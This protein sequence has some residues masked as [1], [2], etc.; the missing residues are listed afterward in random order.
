MKY[1]II[2][3]VIF[4]SGCQTNGHKEFYKGYD[5]AKNFP[6]MKQNI[7]FLIPTEEPKIYNSNNL[8]R[9]IEDLESKRY[10]RIGY[11]RFNGSNAPIEDVINQAK[12]VG[13]LIVLTSSKYT[14]TESSNYTLYMPTTKTSDHNGNVNSTVTTSDSLNTSQVNSTYSGTT[15]TSDTKAYNG[16][17][18]IRRYDQIAMYFAKHIQKLKFG[19]SNRNLNVEERK[20]LGRNTGSLV[21]NVFEKSAAFYA[22][23]LINDLIINI[24]GKEVLDADYAIKMMNDIPAERKSSTLRVIRDGVEKTI[25]VTF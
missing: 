22:N 18:H 10:L 2:L 5:L 20:A 11:S 23:V 9:D 8:R 4:I 6:K 13:A 24:D 15:T 17:Q 25:V 21:T 1:L 3:I 19:L 14:N 16:T 12:S 7:Q